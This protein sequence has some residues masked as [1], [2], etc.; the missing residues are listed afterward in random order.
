MSRG[1]LVLGERTHFRHPR[2]K[3][4]IAEHPRQEV[5]DLSRN[6]FTIK[7]NTRMDF[8]LMLNYMLYALCATVQLYQILYTM[9]IFDLRSS[10]FF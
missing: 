3:G 2:P 5:D 10:M 1:L 7:K 9:R 6:S 8:V 4:Q